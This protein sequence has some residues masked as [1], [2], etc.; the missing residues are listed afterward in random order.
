HQNLHQMVSLINDLKEQIT[1]SSTPIQPAQ[2]PMGEITVEADE[3][4][5]EPINT[6]NN[7]SELDL[8]TGQFVDQSESAPSLILMNQFIGEIT[9]LSGQ[10]SEQSLF[11]TESFQKLAA[12]A[13]QL[14]ERDQN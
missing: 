4:T 3:I 8:I 7:S 5:L 1:H 13:K 9:N 14:S 11:V 6:I 12:F 2:L 10:I